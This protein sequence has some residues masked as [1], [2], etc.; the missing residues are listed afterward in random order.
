LDGCGAMASTT[1]SW[2]N[3]R[4]SAA[5]SHGAKER[6]TTSGRSQASFTTDNATTGGK[7]RLSAGSFLVRQSLEAL[8]HEAPGPCSSMAFS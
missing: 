4:A 5:L 6:P 1:P 8:R 2:T 3:C 7:T